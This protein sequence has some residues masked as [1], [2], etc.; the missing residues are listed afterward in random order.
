MTRPSATPDGVAWHR[1]SHAYGDA[2]DTPGHLRGLTAHDV[3]TR[4]AAL[5]HLWG[6]VLH[7]GS[8][9][10]ATAPVAERLARMLTDPR[11]ARPAR[12]S[13]A[14]STRAE[15][16]SYLGHVAAQAAYH[17]A[18]PDTVAYVRRDDAEVD[19]FEVA[20]EPESDPEYVVVRR[21]GS[22][23]ARRAAVILPLLVPW[24]DAA[25]PGERDAARYAMACWIGLDRG[26]APVPGP[27]LERLT[28][29]ATDT[30]AEQEA[31]IE[32]VLAL[33]AAGADTSD[34]LD[35]AS[36]VIRTCAA[37]SP[38]VVTDRRTLEVITTALRSPL[39]CDQWLRE[40]PPVPFATATLSARLVEAA[41]RCTDDFERLLPAALGVA[42][43]ARP[44]SIDETW[45]PL[46]AA[47][48]TAPP[49]AARPL[50][51]AQRAY[52]SALAANDAL[53][54][55]R[56]EDRDELLHGLGLPVDRGGLL[57][58]GRASY[59]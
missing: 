12:G 39:E 27:V 2:S 37:L 1:L 32:C 35:D 21:V 51:P 42:A 57:A 46:L 29:V 16:L 17:L 4:T 26:A 5:A 6:E 19:A 33:A 20:W 23:C 34:L 38:A 3:A 56:R 22:G 48:V 9:Y 55:R 54:D 7:Q 14:G 49:S 36:V 59:R 58:A 47:A 53:W 28:A 10:T 15:V 18:K 25:D 43:A 41:L 44:W 8:L 50:G 11:L 13:G 45:G 31:R 30:T 52:V 40:S 24:L